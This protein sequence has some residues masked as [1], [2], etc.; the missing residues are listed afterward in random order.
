MNAV[1]LLLSLIPFVLWTQVLD[2][3][4]GN[5]FTDQ[6]FFN[7]SFIK[8]NK[9]KQLY[10][11]FVYKKQG[12]VMKETQFN[13]VYRFDREGQLT[14]LFETRTDDGTPDTNRVLYAYDEKGRILTK[15]KTHQSGYL[16]TRYTY[17]SLGRIRTEE[18][19]S[20]TD[21][22]GQSMFLSFNLES[23]RY[24]EFPAQLKRTRFNS[25]DLPYLV[26]QFITNEHGYLV[27]VNE[28][29][30]MTSQVNTTNYSYNEKGLLSSIRKASNGGKDVEELAFAYD[31]FGNLLQKHIT[32]N[33]I[34][35][36]DIQVVYNS[37]S[38]LLSSVITRQ[39]S[40]NF[41]LIIRFLDY[42]FYE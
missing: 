4:Q 27:E 9:I 2:N 32:K 18:T 19:L 22:A 23:F 6:P 15:K 26:E 25:Y 39:V 41:M 17:D 37:K 34:F 8:A 24:E 20:E 35:T 30:L 16:L 21:S 38:K 13:Y 1:L 31:E 29:Y 5:A 40:T 33:G 7:T 3:S 28:R 12:E 10:G 14:E 42:D 11:T 36:T